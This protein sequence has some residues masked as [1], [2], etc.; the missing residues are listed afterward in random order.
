MHGIKQTSSINCCISVGL[1]SPFFPTSFSNF[2]SSG[3]QVTMNGKYTFNNKL[4]SM[5]NR[6][7]TDTR[8]LEMN[9]LTESLSSFLVFLTTFFLRPD[10]DLAVLIPLT[11]TRTYLKTMNKGKIR[12]A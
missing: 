1:P 2:L 7:D 10:F 4:I 6:R 8:K 3:Y 5:Q 11:A 12:Q 9:A